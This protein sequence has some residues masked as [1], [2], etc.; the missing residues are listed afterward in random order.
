MPYG[1]A[2]VSRY[3]LRTK[4]TQELYNLRLPIAIQEFNLRHQYRDSIMVNTGS[5][6]GDTETG[7]GLHAGVVTANEGDAHDSVL[8]TGASLICA[9]GTVTA[10]INSPSAV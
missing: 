6:P 10:Q 1:S 2:A 8:T 7:Y 5:G 4:E 9:A 3:V